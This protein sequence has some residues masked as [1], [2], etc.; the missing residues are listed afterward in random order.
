M[1]SFEL[2]KIM[3]ALLFACLCLL[4]L[5]IAANAIFT[6]TKLEK[7]GYDIAVPEK[8]APGQQVAAV[9]PAQPIETLLASADIKRGETAAKK[10]QTCHTFVKGGP[11]QVGPNLYGAY[12]RARAATTF[13]Y[14]AAMKAKTGEWTADDLNKFL[15][16]PKTFVPGTTM[17]FAGISRASERADLIAY[18]NSLAD[19]PKPLPKAP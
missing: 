10:C 4:S 16:N 11:N 3:G 7:P 17:G 6:P 19:S 14:S 9:E 8:G 12:D 15:A 18:M 2:N 5:N 13:N 1:D